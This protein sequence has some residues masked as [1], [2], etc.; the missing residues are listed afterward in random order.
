MSAEDKKAAVY[1]SRNISWLGVGS[2]TRG[3]N[4]VKESTVEQWLTQR[5]VR[6]ATVEEVAKEL[7]K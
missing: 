3:I 1:S 4:I 2:L 6:L 5:G 7:D